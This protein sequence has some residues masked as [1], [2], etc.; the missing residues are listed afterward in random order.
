MNPRRKRFA[1]G[2]QFVE[3]LVDPPVFGSAAADV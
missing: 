1:I 3:H 2:F